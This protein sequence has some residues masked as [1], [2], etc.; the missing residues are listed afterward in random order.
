[1]NY[2]FIIAAFIA[3]FFMFIFTY[4]RGIKAGKAIQ[5]NTSIEPIKNPLQPIIEAVKGKSKQEEEAELQQQGLI[6]LLMYDGKPQ[7]RN[8]AE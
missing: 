5:T 3:A 2:I 8:D 7:R 1:M 4:E 6:N